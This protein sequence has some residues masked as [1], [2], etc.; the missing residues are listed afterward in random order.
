MSFG[1]F[2]KFLLLQLSIFNIDM[3]KLKKS[4]NQ[5]FIYLLKNQLYA[6]SPIIQGD[7]N[8]YFTKSKI[9]HYTSVSLL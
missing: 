3:P 6:F 9:T 1:I 2:I 4:Y 7:L 8:L 5:S